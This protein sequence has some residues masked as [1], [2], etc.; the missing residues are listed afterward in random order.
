MVQE[1]FL[2]PEKIDIPLILT[3]LGY[4]TRYVEDHQDKY[5]YVLHK[6]TEGRVFN[7]SIEADGYTPLHMGTLE[8]F[9]GRR[10]GGKVVK[11]LLSKGIIQRDYYV[12]GV[13]SFGYR[14]A[15][16]YM[17]KCVLRMVYK[18]EVMGRKLKLQHAAYGK[19]HEKNLYWK[20]LT[21]F[22]IREEAAVG[23][24][25]E[26][27]A[28]T[29]QQLEVFQASCPCPTP[30]LSLPTP[31]GKAFSEEEVVGVEGGLEDWLS[32]YSSF[33]FSFSPLG[34]GRGG[35]YSLMNVHLLKKS[36]YNTHNQNF[37]PIDVVRNSVINQYNAD[38]ISI[39]K[40]AR[41]RFFIEQ[42][43]QQ[44]R[45][46]TNLSN[47]NSDLRQFLYY[48]P[49]K[50]KVVNLDIRNSQPYLFSLLLMD[51]YRDQPLPDDVALYITLTATGK[52]YEEMM[53]H[54]GVAS[55]DRRAFKIRFFASIF[56]CKAH[57]SQ[58]TV[59]GKVFKT[60]FPNV[61]RLVSHYKKAGH[62]QL[63][64]RMQRAEAFIIL[65]TVGAE[66]G[67]QHIWWSSIH[68]SVVVE[69]AH[70]EA[71][72]ALILKAFMAAVGIPPTIQQE[73][74]TT[75]ELVG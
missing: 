39:K 62:N 16:Q 55:S 40:F 22:G 58:C 8:D 52:F 49:T 41:G 57:Y 46:Y 63:A 20:N 59:E 33:L 72:K 66:L 12:N 2:V 25:D 35:C 73:V 18:D 6:I 64:I 14:I 65:K 42:P 1:Q 68:D 34:G 19:T 50:G 17:S 10:Y 21:K 3:S 44:S 61:S 74:W 75:G 23:Y 43:D 56:F 38:L 4:N 28:F 36:L 7:K 69:E 70:A 71:V 48:K 30:A 29:M 5:N 24:I 13:K 15:P 27:V 31:G 9:L 67:K 45:V 54:L 60:L 47:L 37:T 11:E 32:S 51:Q 26:K 53:V